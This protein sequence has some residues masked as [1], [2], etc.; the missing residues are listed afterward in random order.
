MR[1]QSRVA[2][3]VARY[4][5]RHARGWVS[6]RG[7]VSALIICLALA[8]GTS[9]RAS[10]P[11][12]VALNNPQNPV[13]YGADASGASDS[14]TAFQHAIN[15]GDLDVQAGVY[16]ILGTVHVP[17]ARNIRCEAGAALANQT[18]SSSWTMFKLDGN[19]S[20]SIFNCH[21][22]GP[23]YNINAQP[24]NQRNFEQFITIQSV[25]N[26]GT[27]GNILISGNDFNGVGGFVGS[28]VIYANDS[29]QPPPHNVRIAYNTFQ[30]CGYYAV[31]L[32]SGENNLIDHNT[33]NDCSGFAEADDT[34]QA[35]TGNVF[36]SNHLTFTY[37]IGM[38]Y[39]GC[40]PGC[41]FNG[42]TGGSNAS[43]GYFNY[44]GNTVKN[45]IVDGTHPSTIMIN[46][47]C[48]P[49]QYNNN[50]CT[51]GCQIN[52]YQ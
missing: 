15:A 38:N 49:A 37:G 45:N 33:L 52:V 42:L 44:S 17:D 51:G 9:A 29:N 18:S 8:L 28:I 20:G 31:Q 48:T 10:A 11:A 21:F 4:V 40:N 35:N 39:P 1:N 41:G 43:G 25:N 36:D 34:A 5:S 46:G 32:G 27:T 12:P 6:Y 19:T 14:T 3:L 24:G 26:N 23:N 22:R 2:N 7:R 16:K 47:N 13:S 50:T 30:H